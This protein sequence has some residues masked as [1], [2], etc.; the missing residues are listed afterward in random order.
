[1]PLP[2]FGV[3]GLSSKIGIGLPV[4]IRFSHS[5]KWIPIDK[6]W[7]LKPRTWLLGR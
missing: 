1:M 3:T 4:G 7:T 2:L 5:A 6:P